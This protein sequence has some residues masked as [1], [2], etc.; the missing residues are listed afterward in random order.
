MDSQT[1]S[2]ILYMESITD[3]RK[4]MSAARH[5]ATTKPIVV[6]KA[7]HTPR[8]A[9]A[10]GWHTGAMAGD[11]GLYAAAFRRAGI[12]RVNGIEDL[13]DISETLSGQSNPRGPR[14]A[15]LTNAGGPG[16]MATDVLL[17]SGGE[18]AEISPETDALLQVTLPGF[19]ARGNP[20]DI[21]GDADENRYAAACLAL[22]DDPNVDGVLAVLTPQA[23]TH[24]SATARALIDSIQM[25]TT[26]PLLTS[27]MGLTM[28][29][30]AVEIFRANHIP[31]FNTPEDAVRAYMYMVQYTRNL[32]LLYETPKDILPSFKPDRAK[33][34]DI[35]MRLARA[36]CGRL[37]EIEAKAVLDAYGIPTA[38]AVLT[39]SPEDAAKTADKVGFPLA[40][41]VISRDIIGKSALG[42]VALNIHSAEEAGLQY[43][44]LTESV[45]AAS[46]EAD[47][48]GIAIEPMAPRGGYEVVMTSRRDATFGPYLRFAMGGTGLS[49]YHDVSFGF[50]PLNETLARAMIRDT[51]V[52]NLLDEHHGEPSV[53]IEALEQ[54]LVKFSYL[55]VDFPE[56]VEV[57]VD[58]LHVR[59][60]GVTA[61]DARVLIDP[62]EVHKVALPGSHLIISMY[63]SKYDW[64]YTIEGE[65]EPV[66]LRPIRPEDEPLWAEM[67]NSLSEA[68]AQYRFFGPVKQIPRSMQVRYCHVDYDREIAIVA[69]QKSKKKARMLGV[70]RLTKD[71][72]SADEG[73]F[74]IVI[75]DECQG[76]GVG[77]QLMQA[78]IQA[79]RDQHINE[80][81]GEVLS[82][83]APMLAF[84]EALGF[85]RRSSGDPELRKI[86]L[87]V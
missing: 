47:I 5:F 27:F 61:L 11:D 9:L 76:K 22:M 42:G 57:D 72:R 55:L 18:L 26:K 3:A 8:A 25:H 31:A 56:I 50:P 52:S 59:A 49:L 58:P 6:V 68:T 7:G 10:A 16:V 63:P 74:A 75:R 20:V 78:L 79:A 53:D 38:T 51:K 54:I 23:M 67:I 45:R 28:T 41:K 14:L 32:A 70:A 34:K 77:S 15:I 1:H 30:D 24:P 39:T 84:A 37:T 71:P 35:F 64:E 2:I 73:E 86:V 62:K 17:D 19:A 33:V 13:F 65:K 80:I 46:P 12:V 4:F 48:M 81:W 21:G 29:A 87:H 44:K 85:E 36:G 60:D 43:A 40:M 82:F 83:N 66:R 69:I